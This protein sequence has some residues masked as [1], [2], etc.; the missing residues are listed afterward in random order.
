MPR[1]QLERLS[2]PLAVLLMVSLACSLPGQ[3]GTPQ[4][5]TDQLTLQ[6]VGTQVALATA[7]AGGGAP[8][9]TE[10]PSGATPAP[11]EATAVPV[12]PTATATV[13]H[14]S[15]PSNPG[16]TNSFMTDRSSKALASER[17]AIADNFD[18]L[19]FERPFTS[20]NMDYEGYVDITRGELSASSPWYYVTISLEDSPPADGS[21][22]Y[23]VEVDIDKDG[24]G[25]WLIWGLAPPD[26]NWTTDGVQALQDTNNDVGGATP[27]K[28]DLPPQTGN[29]YDLVAFDSGQG[30]DPDSAWIR[31]S[32]SSG[33]Q[34]QIAFKQGL[35]GAPGEFMWGVWA[36]AGPQDPT[37][38]DYNDHFSPAD[39]G[40]P[41]SGSSYYPLNQ[42][43]Q[44]DN[45]CRWGYGFTPVGTEPGACY[46]PPTPTPTFTA[47]PTPTGSI[48]GYV[49][50]GT[51]SSP[52]STRFSG[53]TVT[54]GQG[55]CSSS[56]YRSTKTGSDG[57]YSFNEL[58][59]GTYCVTVKKS[60]LP[61]ASYG[62]GTMYPSGFGGSG[63]P[64]QQVN[65]GADEHR[66]NVNFAFLEIVG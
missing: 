12:E 59:P 10:V 53:V 40:S 17:R 32:P 2:L 39:A 18:T 61:A 33:S 13:V 34:I 4:V 15:I 5:S 46:V 36:D 19:L 1:R 64:Y 16:S 24:R 66:S 20:Q 48:S 63:N 51:G 50:R 23:G 62:W 45:S 55:S 6:A 30:S 52:G 58:P 54:L 11:A 9:A 60:G 3:L 42:L 22:R 27:I 65:L 44:V 21:V 38:F 14:T 25:D 31:R 56:G 7:G 43:A 26:S 28:A 41:V 57:S 37:W 29:G 8:A 49:Y 47:T 35:I